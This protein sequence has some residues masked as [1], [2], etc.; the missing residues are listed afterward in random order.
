[1]RLRPGSEA[2]RELYA[3]LHVPHPPLPS[4]SFRFLAPQDAAAP[5]YNNLPLFFLALPSAPPHLPSLPPLQQD[6]RLRPGS[7][8][9]RELYANLPD[10]VE[11]VHSSARSLEVSVGLGPSCFRMHCLEP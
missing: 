4:P 11:E 10:N 2:L 6:M 9:L 7:E 5:I 3:N 8:A 1:M